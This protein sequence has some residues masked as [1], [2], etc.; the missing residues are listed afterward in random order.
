MTILEIEKIIIATVI[1]LQIFIFIKEM[2]I[3]NKFKLIFEDKLI[4]IKGKFDK[5]RLTVSKNILQEVK[6]N[7]N[8]ILE[9]FDANGNE[10]K[11]VDSN[12]L[13]G[14]S[15]IDTNS[16]NESLKRIKNTLNSYLTN[17]YGAAVNFSIIKDIVDRE[18]DVND[19]SISQSLPVPLY[20]GLAA[21]M[22]GIILGLFSMPSINGD[23]F[24]T[25][26][27]SLID[28][29]KIAMIASL[30]GLILTTILSTIIY[31]NAKKKV[32]IDKNDQLS[33]L[34]AEL[35]PE[36][37]KAEDTGVSG[38]KASLDRFAREATTISTNVLS[39]ANKTNE[40][41]QK[42]NEVI[43]KIEKLNMTKVSRA[44]L[45]LFDRIESNF[46]ML[47]KFNGYISALQNI[48]ENLVE[49]SKRSSDVEIIASE[50]KEN[51][52]NSN[53]IIKLL[54]THTEALT[55]HIEQI[56]NSGGAA[57]SA[58]DSADSAFSEAIEKLQTEINVRMISLSKSADSLDVNL[59]THFENI[60]SNLI[61]TTSRHLDELSSVYEGS[62][63]KFEQLD[64]LILLPE[65][66][67]D[68]S[69]QSQELLNAINQLNRSLGLI[70][71]QMSNQNV[72][73][74]LEAIEKSINRR[75]IP[76]SAHP[77]SKKKENIFRKIFNVK[78]K[79]ENKLEK[80]Q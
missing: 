65:I 57:C 12:N 10:L 36:L 67:E 68:T 43:D 14:L 76:Y 17:N 27:N 5:T 64:N 52:N 73:S 33:F 21:T 44:N 37:V 38:L 8:Q 51:M 58:V 69:R 60:G 54:K 24:T 1:L 63:P 46:I 59:Q 11:V 28:G 25:G 53:T 70:S 29:V 71:N 3:I 30:A 26:I 48:S 55:A 40:N 79:N 9:Y 42:Q 41:L 78:S 45:E 47:N 23:G 39:A 61:E 32:L 74:K 2:I 34:Q 56:K 13:I 75:R 77:T 22:V 16:E 19:E 72:I 15:L 31:K 35:L 66:K 4:I 18:V 62:V 6:N 50:I 80:N 20:L 7:S 49:F